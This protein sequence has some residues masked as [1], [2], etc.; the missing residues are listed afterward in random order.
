MIITF[1]AILIPVCVTIFGIVY[2]LFICCRGN[3]GMLSG[4]DNALM[5]IPTTFLSLIVW[6]IYAILK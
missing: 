5:L 2:S 3:T 6:I 1:S 4:L